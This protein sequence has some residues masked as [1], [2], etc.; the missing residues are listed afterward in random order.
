MT[1]RDRGMASGRP[2]RKARPNDGLRPYAGEGPAPSV[3]LMP[4]VVWNDQHGTTVLSVLLQGA[5]GTSR[6][7]Y[8]V[9]WR[10]TVIAECDTLERATD[11]L[12]RL[13]LGTSRPPASPERSTERTFVSGR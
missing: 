9:V 5:D 2:C 6:H 11:C 8:Q 10:G 3:L 13:Q 12:R 1:G 7:V 4:T